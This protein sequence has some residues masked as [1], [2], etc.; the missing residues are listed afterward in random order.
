MHS[1][2]P[3]Q[4]CT[5]SFPPPTL[6]SSSPDLPPSR[7]TTPLPPSTSV[8]SPVQRG[9]NYSPISALKRDVKIQPLELIKRGQ[10]ERKSFKT[11]LCEGRPDGEPGQPTHPQGEETPRQ[12]SRLSAPRCHKRARCEERRRRQSGNV[13]V[14]ERR[15]TLPNLYASF[16][17]GS[18]FRRTKATPQKFDLS[19]NS[20]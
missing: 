10:T 5:R 6:L 8:L 3:V 4:E 2:P 1:L 20:V 16:Q 19:F 13:Q 17:H 14:F 7:F 18:V 12:P 15:H 11:G 9:R